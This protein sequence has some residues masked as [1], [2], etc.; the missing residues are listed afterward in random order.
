MSI[1]EDVM[2]TWSLRAKLV[3]TSLCA[4][5]AATLICTLVQRS[6]IRQQGIDLTRG[7][8]RGV[9]LGAENIRESVS[10]MRNDGVFRPDLL[11][12]TGTAG[13][14]D[15]KVFQ[16]VPVV[17]AW[18]AIELVAARE[19]Y[20]FH[21]AARSPRNAKHQPRPEELAILNHLESGSAEDYFG[22]DEERGEVVYARPIRLSKD[23][24]AC[25]G[26]PQNSPSGNGRDVL[27]FPMENWTAGQI[28]GVFVLRSSLSRLTPA[29]QASM[30]TALYWILPLAA[31]VGVL[32]GWIVNRISL[33]LSGIASIL[34]Q[35]ARNVDQATVQL[36]ASATA[37]AQGAS[38]QAASIEETSATSE[39]IN[40]M[41]RK[42]SDNSRRAVELVG[43][44]Q[45]EFVHANHALNDMVTAM[46]DI[47]AQ[48]GRISKIIKVID[49]IA[50]Q[51]NLLALN[52]A[53]EA[54]RA[55]EAGMGFAVV[56]DEV[57][58]LAQRSA[59]AAR[60]TTAM[61]EESI[62]KSSAGKLRMDQVASSIR[63]VTDESAGIRALV[64]DMHAASLEQA[65]GIDIITR[66]L[67]RMDQ[68]TQ[69]TAAHA[70]EG[71]S[72]A[73]QLGAQSETLRDMVH[74][75]AAVVEGEA[76]LS[77]R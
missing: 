34:G 75:L 59:Q 63:V 62:S 43:R 46:S 47:E 18:R 14:S 39:Q 50:F 29:I 26:H 9:L 72:A 40:A 68:V 32:V 51:T 53:V 66:A 49:E 28:H 48:S 31:L 42:N 61:I 33:R 76:A 30:R 4:I 2:S 45:G 56:A 21:I 54:A 25:H 13:N 44:S 64:E 71:A 41:A 52:A 74:Q 58:N 24:L 35:G 10:A 67:N 27:G 19:G 22:V 36:S 16:T 37:L 1:V 7:S 5:G 65:K 55:G 77:H 12:A 6:I 70:E 57:R 3:V 15:A 60:D 20:Q 23:C 69:S 11:N 17:A 73:V 8:M 38:E